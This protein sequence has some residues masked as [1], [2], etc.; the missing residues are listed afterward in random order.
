MQLISK[1]N[2]I[3]IFDDYAHHPTE[4]KTTLNGLK[5][6]LNK[7]I[8]CI[9]QPHRYSR[10]KELLSSFFSAFNEADQVIITPIYTANECNSE[11]N[12]KLILKLITGIRKESKN[13]S[14]VIF[15]ESNKKILSH[16][17]TTIQKEDIIITMGAG[18]I[19]SI[20]KDLKK[21]TCDGGVQN[22]KALQL[23]NK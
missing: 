2:N 20:S 9:F 7:S 8:T 1:E 3:M 23:S 11:E 19:H 15:L 21:I 22:K 16:I 10:T 12:K 13:S 4:I 17:Q 5:K 14:K 18:N 6:A